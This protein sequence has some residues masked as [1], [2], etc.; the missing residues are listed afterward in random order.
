M[1]RREGIWRERMENRLFAIFL[2][3]EKKR[4]G[5]ME[6]HSKLKNPFSPR[7]ER[8]GEKRNRFK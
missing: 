6:D 2:R 3:E 5:L 7:V 1:E 8:N 4:S